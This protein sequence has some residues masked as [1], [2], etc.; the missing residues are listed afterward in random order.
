MGHTRCKSDP[1]L[2][3]ARRA[4]WPISCLLSTLLSCA[5]GRPPQ[6]LS[7][8]SLES[9]P[10]GEMHTPQRCVV[11]DA[12]VLTPLCRP[13]SPRLG[14]ICVR[15]ASDWEIFRRAVPDAGQKP[16]FS[17]GM[18][19]GVASFAGQPLSGT[20]PIEIEYVRIIQGAGLVSA[21]FE[22]GNYLPDG[23]TFIE[24]TFVPTLQTVLVVDINGVRFL[25]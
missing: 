2:R 21:H 15:T 11:S 24:T 16:D 3:C 5:S 12:D 8:Q 9:A 18:L 7:L 6:T 4:I 17:R 22:G 20:W 13:L 19:L 14:L 23:T 10:P 1:T 25:P